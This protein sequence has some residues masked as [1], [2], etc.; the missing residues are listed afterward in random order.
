MDYAISVFIFNAGTIPQRK[1]ILLSLHKQR[2]SR[3]SNKNRH[4]VRLRLPLRA[5]VSQQCA[6]S[7]VTVLM[8]HLIQI[9]DSIYCTHEH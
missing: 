3:F 1:Q 8:I 5:Q 9:V 7:R 4:H 6:A 2:E